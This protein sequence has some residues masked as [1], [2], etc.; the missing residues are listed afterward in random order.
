MDDGNN[1]VW[2]EIDGLFIDPR[3][4]EPALVT[5][6]RNR[7]FVP[8]GVLAWLEEPRRGDEVEVVLRPA[9]RNGELIAVKIR[10]SQL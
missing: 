6:L 1:W 5:D 8:P 4:Q 3:G 2:V 7:N 10:L 9:T